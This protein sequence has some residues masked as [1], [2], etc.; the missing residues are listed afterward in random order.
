[1]NDSMKQ[2][3]VLKNRK[4]LFIS[5]VTKLEALNQVE[6]SLITNL[7]RMIV[8]GNNMEMQMLDI[9]NG[10]INITGDIDYIAYSNKSSKEKDK[11]FI[12]K[13]FK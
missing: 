6:F 5:G 4:E 12:Q 13:L 2:D 9:E 7:G 1:M 3:V 11:G 10:N 8:K